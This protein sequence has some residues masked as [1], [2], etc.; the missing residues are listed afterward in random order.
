MA[1]PVVMEVS[2]EPVQ[3]EGLKRRR[4]VIAELPPARLGEVYV[5]KTNGIFI[6]YGERHV[7]YTDRVVVDAI[8]VSLVQMRPQNVRVE[9]LAGEYTVLATFRCRVDDP[10]VA[11]RE[12]LTDMD[13]LLAGYLH[14]AVE[15]HPDRREVDAHVRAYCVV[16][17]PEVP[18]VDVV[19][20]TVRVLAPS[21]LLAEQLYE[22][23]APNGGQR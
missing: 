3:R 5:F 6:P 14:E 12:S 9:A 8:Q 23:F 15:P 1:Y 13:V 21:E 11:A 20:A 2:L 18:G 17:P 19:L 4:R 22:D 16:A 7:R 10:A